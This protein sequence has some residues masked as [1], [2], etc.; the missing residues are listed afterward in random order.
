VPTSVKW[1]AAMTEGCLEDQMP[2]YIDA[3][4]MNPESIRLVFVFFLP[5]I[6]SLSILKTLFPWLLC[7]LPELPSSY[8]KQT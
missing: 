6:Y 5:N 1:D 8:P 7:K 2:G 3:Q 4:N